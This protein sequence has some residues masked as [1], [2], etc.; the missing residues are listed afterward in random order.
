MKVK[1]LKDLTDAQ[2]EA[3]VHYLGRSLRYLTND[4]I[5]EY[6]DDYVRMVHKLYTIASDEMIKRWDRSEIPPVK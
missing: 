3:H 4:D 2:L 1:R 6:T 5:I